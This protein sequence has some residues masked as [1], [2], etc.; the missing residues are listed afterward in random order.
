MSIWEQLNN[1]G[2]T[3]EPTEPVDLPKL[4]AAFYE[5]RKLREAQGDLITLG[6]FMQF[7]FPRSK[8]RRTR[9]KWANDIR[10]YRR[11]EL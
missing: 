8:K 3:I 6:T 10:N 11:V 7:R 2:R 4:F 5:M 1:C 9:Q